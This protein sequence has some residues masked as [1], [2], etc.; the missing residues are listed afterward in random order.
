ME[1]TPLLQDE[2]NHQTSLP[3]HPIMKAHPTAY[4]S[5]KFHAPIYTSRA[6]TSA[7]TN[8]SRYVDAQMLCRHLNYFVA[9]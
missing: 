6:L 7:N 8:T 2:T 3:Y 5:A 1:T 9:N 4:L